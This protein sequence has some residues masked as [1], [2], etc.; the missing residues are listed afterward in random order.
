MFAEVL[1]GIQLVKT[2]VSFIKESIGTCKDVSE[3]VDAVDSLL[4]G[5]SQINKDRSK[6]D[7]V[8]IKDQLG[9]KGVAQEVIDA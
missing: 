5:E 7:G 2:S 8:S 6:K 1:T 4:D 3:I 9:L